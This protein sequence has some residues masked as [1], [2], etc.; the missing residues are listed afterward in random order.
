[1]KILN[2]YGARREP[3]LFVLDYE[4][5]S[6]RIYPLSELN[7]EDIYYILPSGGNAT[8]QT[9]NHN[10]SFKKYPVAPEIYQ[11]SFDQVKEEF[12]K[13]NTFLLNLSF[14]TPVECDLTLRE[15]FQA[16]QA[17][18]R[19]L[20]RDEFVVFSPE[21]FVRIQNDTIS[22]FPMK[23]TID[24]GLPHARKQLLDDP[25]ELAEHTAIVDLLRN[26]LSRVARNVRVPRF[27]YIEA[28]NAMDKTLLQASSEI[29]GD[30]APDWRDRLGDIFAEL[31]PAGSISGTP[32]ISTCAIISR[33]E[34]YR[35]GYFSG[36]F[37][38]FDGESVDSG[39]MIR[40]LERQNQQLVFK[41]GGGLM[42]YSEWEKEYREML[43][44]VY[45][46]IFRNHSM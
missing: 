5:L 23:G 14:P 35:R 32:K 8:G 26:D 21:S 34:N 1:M 44:K 18:Y 30:L 22:T 36:V 12:I 39:V 28:I 19:L 15:I 3:C 9:L 46:P 6:P 24:E 25:K 40:Y 42:V 41:S 10:F 33:V 20:F 27:R 7:R 31:L 13:G 4:L 38:V 37:G 43:E 17:P 16:S 11:Y 29:R 2:T 45:V